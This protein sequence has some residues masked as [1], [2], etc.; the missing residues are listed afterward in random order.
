MNLL[1]GS[2]FKGL[3]ELKVWAATVVAKATAAAEEILENM[4]I[5]CDEQEVD[6][7]CGCCFVPSELYSEHGLPFWANNRLKWERT[8]R[9]RSECVL[10]AKMKTTVKD[11]SCSPRK[12]LQFFR[13]ELFDR[14]QR[15]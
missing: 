5:D 12:D 8:V 2:T 1:L 13:Y 4:M 10:C 11:D 6:Q 15:V 3:Q 14:K 9:R 7:A